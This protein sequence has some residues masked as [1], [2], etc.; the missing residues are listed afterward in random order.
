M[1]T[2][3]E[4]KFEC[5]EC[6]GTVIELPDN[7]TDDSIAKCEAC[8]TAFGTWGD[9][10]AKAYDVAFDHVANSFRADLKKVARGSKHL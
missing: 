6:G 5:L 7:P 9:V 1:K 3:L 2:E 4:F 8:G 10:Q